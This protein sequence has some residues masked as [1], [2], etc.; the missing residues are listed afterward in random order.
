MDY[1]DKFDAAIFPK[2][3]PF[4]LWRSRIA[5]WNDS[6]VYIRMIRFYD[7]IQY[8]RVCFRSSRLNPIA[9][10]AP[11]NLIS[12]MRQ[13]HGVYL[14]RQG[15]SIERLM[16]RREGRWRG[17]AW[18][19]AS[20]ARAWLRATGGSGVRAFSALTIIVIS[21]Y[22]YW[23][24]CECWILEGERPTVRIENHG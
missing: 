11:V 6:D 13:R 15:G 24:L 17:W 16:M 3:C 7:K 1:T 9:M 4:V 19:T 14:G 2:S 18:D 10:W 21:Y 8:F 23:I 22:Q 20:R 5:P 12:N